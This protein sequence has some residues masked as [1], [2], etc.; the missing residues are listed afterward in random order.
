MNLK[1]E[2]KNWKEKP[3]V[4]SGLT[5]IPTTEPE[6]PDSQQRVFTRTEQGFG[7]PLSTEKLG[8]PNEQLVQPGHSVRPSHADLITESISPTTKTILEIGVNLYKGSLL[9]TTKCILKNKTD[10]CIYLGVDIMDK[11]YLDDA[12]R[13]IHT[14]EISSLE[15][16]AIRKRMLELKMSTI[17]L[18]MIDGYHSIEMTI[19]DWCFVEFLSPLGIVIIHDTNVHSGPRAVFDA[20]DK[21][22]FD[23]KLISS[24]IKD[25]KFP[26][27]GIGIARRLF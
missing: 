9:S 22:S 24:E 6:Y 18:L 16:N 3:S 4:T 23:K 26:D 20:I 13:N 17:D 25:G 2:I 10:S 21:T 12:N 19:N 11:S 15:R 5:Y 1:N 8:P 27:Y 7:F 14:M